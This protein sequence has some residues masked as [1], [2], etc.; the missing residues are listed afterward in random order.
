MPLNFA[1]E[2][3]KRADPCNYTP[4][5]TKAQQRRNFAPCRLSER[6]SNAQHQRQTRH[7]ALATFKRHQ[8]ATHASTAQQARPKQRGA[9]ASAFV[10]SRFWRYLFI[11]VFGLYIFLTFLCLLSFL[12]LRS[13]PL[14]S[15]FL[16]RHA[17]RN[18]SVTRQPSALAQFLQ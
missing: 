9:I 16:R 2:R 5:A 3:T 18:A 4:K 15:Y 8:S 17:V 7:N 6:E 10:K 1:T 12:S 14:L 13:R 11:K